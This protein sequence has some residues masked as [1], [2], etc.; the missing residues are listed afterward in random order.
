MS[1]FG[2]GNLGTLKRD[3]IRTRLLAFHAEFYSTSIMTLVIYGSE[4]VDT[5]STWARELFT[6]ARDLGISKPVFNGHPSGED[7]VHTLCRVK[8]VRDLRYIEI[9]F[10]MPETESAYKIKPYHINI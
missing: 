5:L 8:P 2:T 6:D 10:P 1:F 7:Q 9:V 3:D 4:G